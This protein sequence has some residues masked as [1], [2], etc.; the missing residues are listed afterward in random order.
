MTS[1][2]DQ[3]TFDFTVPAEPRTAEVII[4]PAENMIGDLRDTGAEMA[5]MSPRDRERVLSER[6]ARYRRRRL[7]M[8]AD[9]DDVEHNARAYEAAL[10]EAIERQR[11]IN[12][13]CGYDDQPGETA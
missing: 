3:L 13:L 12:F 5:L 11:V 4:F 7:V 1:K 8:G 6:L 10:R 9:A 2:C